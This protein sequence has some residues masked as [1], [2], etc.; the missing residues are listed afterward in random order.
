MAKTILIVDDE[1][2]IRTLLHK[3]LAT[4]G[5]SPIAAANGEEMY[6]VLAGARPDL[7]LLDIML[8]VTDGYELCRRLKQ[9]PATRGIPVVLLSVLATAADIRRGLDL[10]AEAYLT[11]PFDPA[12]LARALRTLLS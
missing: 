1:E 11:K 6:R 12:V 8:P 5:W 7:I 10:G 2:D 4:E 3:V 9:D